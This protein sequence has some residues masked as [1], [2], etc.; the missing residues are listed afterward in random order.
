MTHTADDIQFDEH[1]FVPHFQ[2][3]SISG[4]DTSG[5]PLEDLEHASSLLIKALEMRERYMFLSGQSF[6]QT[7]ERFLRTVHNR[8]MS[9]N[10]VEYEDKRTTAGEYLYWNDSYNDVDWKQ[11]FSH[12]CLL[13]HLNVSK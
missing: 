7:T 6:P 8:K 12:F 1:E 4:E 11:Y 3:V 13:S 9:T 2:R 10:N 5:V